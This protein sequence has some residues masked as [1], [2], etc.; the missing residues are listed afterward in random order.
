MT[1]RDVDIEVVADAR[2]VALLVAGRLAQQARDGGS[3]VLTGGSTPRVAYELAAELEPDWSR[4]EVWWGDE[5]CVPPDDQASNYAM[6]KRA[7]LDRLGQ[8]PAAIHRMQGELGRDEGAAEYRHELA[9]VG[10]FD[11][12][13]LGLGPDGHIASLFPGFPTLDVTNRDVVG[14]EAGHEPFIDRISLTL[15]RLCRT[16]ELLFVVTGE[17]KADA[18]A[19][20]LAGEPS[21]EAPGSL[22]RASEGTTRAVLDPA[23]AARLPR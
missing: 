4:V 18:V 5:R 2:E 8:P 6:A 12:V 22:A 16:R 1:G 11:L 20:A 13:L 17:G 3:V 19:R 21:H 9:G 7:L 23:A 14:S 10:A 15:P